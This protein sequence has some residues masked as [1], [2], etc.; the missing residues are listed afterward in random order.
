MQAFIKGVE[1]ETPVMIPEDSSALLIGQAQNIIDQLLADVT[2]L[3]DPDSDG[4]SVPDS[5][6]ST[7]GMN[8]LSPDSDG[9]N[10][11]DG[12]ELLHTGTDPLDTDTDGNGT[13]DGDEDPDQDGCTTGAEAGQTPGQGGERD[14]L[15]LWDVADQWTGGGKDRS[16]VIGDIGAVIARFGTTRGSAPTK[17]EAIDEA[18]TPPLDMTG[19]H[20]S[21]DRSGLNPNGGPWDLYP[22]DGSIVIGDI[23][24]VV[25]QFGHS[26][27]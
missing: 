14:P 5:A 4:D 17:Q 6:E 19:Y 8:P 26:C 10:V 9:D 3:P 25:A 7:L 12:V 22:P 18:L 1:A 24:A 21:A 23:G 11:P 13:S 16:V 20:A 27:A 2:C 15:S